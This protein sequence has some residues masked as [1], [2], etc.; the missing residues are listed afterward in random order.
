MGVITVHCEILTET[1]TISSPWYEA[2]GVALHP[3]VGG[4]LHDTGVGNKLSA[5]LKA[6]PS[7]PLTLYHQHADALF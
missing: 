1:A 2:L 5:L 6:R 7:Y 4:E 3:G